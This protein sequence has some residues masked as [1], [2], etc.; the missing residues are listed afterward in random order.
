M[1]DDPSLEPGQSFD[2]ATDGI[3][4]GRP[5]TVA[6]RGFIVPI[7]GDLILG[8]SALVEFA[9]GQFSYNST[10]GLV[11]GGSAL[12][13]FS[14]V[15]NGAGGLVIGGTANTQTPSRGGAVRRPLRRPATQPTITWEPAEPQ[16]ELSPFDYL[17]RIQDKIKQ[18]QPTRF[19]YISGGTLHVSGSSKITV[20]Y[21]DVPNGPIVFSNSAPPEPIEIDVSSLFRDGNTNRELAEFEDRLML[22]DLLGQGDYRIKTG[23]KARFVHCNTKGAASVSFK[24]AGASATHTNFV[25]E[26][27]KSEDEE[28]VLGDDTRLTWSHEEEELKLLGIIE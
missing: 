14:L 24:S 20:V 10:G 17:K 16:Y 28:L 8:G 15:V 13:N 21:R 3:G 12:A 1:T 6:T 26:L 5:I 7:L 25:A 4:I 2:I 9:T 22:S 18:H 23:S 11:I 19:D 27:I